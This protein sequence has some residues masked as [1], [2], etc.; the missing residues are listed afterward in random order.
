MKRITVPCKLTVNISWKSEWEDVEKREPSHTVE[1]E[2][3]LVQPLC[4]T[5]QRFFRKLKTELPYDPALPLLGIYVEKMDMSLS[6]LQELVMDRETWHAAVHGVAKSQ[7]RLSNGTTSSVG[8]QDAST[9]QHF[10]C[11]KQSLDMFNTK[12]PYL[13]WVHLKRG[14][15]S[16]RNN[17]LQN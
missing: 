16:G 11:W 5:A 13:F 12:K 4:R 7:T 3:K 14:T 15:P 2:R 6:K 10:P 17:L 8:K 9:N 1:E